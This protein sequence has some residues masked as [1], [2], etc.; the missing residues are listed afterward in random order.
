MVR[1]ESQADA[2]TVKFNMNGEQRMGWHTPLRINFATD[3]RGDWDCPSCGYANFA[4][5]TECKQCGTANPNSQEQ[6]KGGTGAEA[7]P[8]ELFGKSSAVKEGF[9]AIFGPYGNARAAATEPKRKDAGL[10][11][12][13]GRRPPPKG[14]GKGQKGG[15]AGG[16]AEALL[17]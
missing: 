17:K 5:K 3:K 8:A 6:G 14:K 16:F 13:R 2:K 4:I 12:Q 7:S 1:F 9:D 15:F 10:G 11:G